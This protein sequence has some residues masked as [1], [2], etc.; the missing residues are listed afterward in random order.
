MFRYKVSRYGMQAHRHNRPAQEVDEYFATCKK[1]M[2]LID[3][4]KE[5]FMTVLIDKTNVLLLTQKVP[6]DSI[7]DQLDHKIN[8]LE[9]RR[10]FRINYQ[11][12]KR[13]KKRL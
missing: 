12:T 1:Y 7:E 6:N 13:V 11:R 8:V 5:S 10:Y 9:S 2:E 3:Y 4:P